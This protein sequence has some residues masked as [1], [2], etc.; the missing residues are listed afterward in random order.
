M[1]TLYISYIISCIQYIIYIYIYHVVLEYKGLMAC[2]FRHLQ[3]GDALWKPNI[4][5]EVLYGMLF[6]KIFVYRGLSP[7]P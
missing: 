6:K 1:Y 7:K 3:E 4:F 5:I 2:Y